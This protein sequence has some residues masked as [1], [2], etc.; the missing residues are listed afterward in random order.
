MFRTEYLN[1]TE[2]QKSRGVIYS[3]RLVVTNNP[4]I[5]NGIIHEVFGDDPD[6]DRMIRNLENVGFFEGM[7][8]DLGWDVV[9]EVRR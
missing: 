2:E 4:H 3:S 6:K 1:L 8:N 7:A 5:D 9:N